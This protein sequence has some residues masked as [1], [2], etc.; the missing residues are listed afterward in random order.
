ML[1][2]VLT[3]TPNTPQ[4]EPTGGPTAAPPADAA[5]IEPAQNR[6]D[7]AT[8]EPAR[9]PGA[10]RGN[11]SAARGPRKGFRS[12]RL[13][14][15]CEHQEREARKLRRR[16]EEKL[17]TIWPGDGDTPVRVTMALESLVRLEQLVRLG[18]KRMAEL[19]ATAPLSDHLS[20][21]AFIS[22][23][24]R[25]RDA[26]LDR[27]NTA[28]KEEAARAESGVI[29]MDD[30]FKRARLRNLSAADDDEA[31]AAPA[32]GRADDATETPPDHAGGPQHGW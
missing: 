13:P 1:T 28:V 3:N 14:D 9:G 5:R 12:Q 2:E 22:R 4:N 17:E 15:G 8:L 6:P 10:P 16:I 30:V 11:L 24:T 25:A 20:V 18:Y 7:A 21:M 29:D 27:L 19:P 32:S 23:E 31:P 26:C